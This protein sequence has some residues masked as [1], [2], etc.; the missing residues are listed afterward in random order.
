MLCRKKLWAQTVANKD[1]AAPPNNLPLRK[2]AAR[3][4][5]AGAAQRSAAQR[6]AAL[7]RA[8]PHRATPRHT[9][10]HPYPEREKEARANRQEI[11]DRVR[12]SLGA[13]LAQ[14][15]LGTY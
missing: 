4:N 6:D 2:G 11:R 12:P 14:K 10:P 9:T 15:Q 5:S 13:A 3:R 1:L 8:A 7:G